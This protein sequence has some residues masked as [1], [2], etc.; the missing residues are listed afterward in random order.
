MGV[1]KTIL[2]PGNGVDFPKQ[3]DNVAM[4]YTGCLYDASAAA[5]YYMG[6]KFDSSRDRGSPLTSPIGVGRLIRGWDEGVPQMSLG[7]KAILDISSDFGYGARGFPD[8]IP[9]NS[10]LVFEVE[11]VGINNKKAASA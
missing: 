5:N 9:E 11:L 2:S 4:H 7:E 6:K 1:E 10:R 3:G 8:L